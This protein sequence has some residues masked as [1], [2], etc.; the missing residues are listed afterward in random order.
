MSFL[1]SSKPLSGFVS[2][3]L[4]IARLASGA[5]M[6]T[7]GYPKLMRL[8]DGRAEGFPDPLGVGS[9]LS[10]ILAVGA[11]VIGSVLIMLGVFTRFAA[12][13]LIFT[14][15]V[16]AFVIHANDPFARMEM[17]LLYLLLFATLFVFGPGKYAI[18]R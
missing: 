9:L 10:L 11:E 18:D 6:L 8:I 3:W 15:L 2:V 4:L 7:H 13:S 12:F 14:M 16:A 1:T 5:F 17:S